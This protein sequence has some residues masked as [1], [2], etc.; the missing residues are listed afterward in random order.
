MTKMSYTE[1]KNTNKEKIGKLNVGNLANPLKG[2]IKAA[3]EWK[4]I[5]PTHITNK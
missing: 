3:T 1:F 2:I 4:K 5:F